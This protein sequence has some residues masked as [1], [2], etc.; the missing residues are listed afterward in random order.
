MNTA[1]N[2]FLSLKNV[3]FFLHNISCISFHIYLSFSYI[4]FFFR[5]TKSGLVRDPTASKPVKRLLPA[6]FTGHRSAA[7]T[8][9]RSALNVPT[10]QRSAG[11]ANK[12]PANQPPV[13][14]QQGQSRLEE[15]ASQSRNKIRIRTID[16]K[17]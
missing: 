17:P 6:S 7:K 9:Q 10:N 13:R 12:R 11:P 8:N 2:A 14:A 3:V 1:S 16:N 4:L 15:A 5:T